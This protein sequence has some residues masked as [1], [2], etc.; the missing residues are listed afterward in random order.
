MRDA[1]TVQLEMQLKINTQTQR[2][3]KEENGKIEMTAV[4]AASA[5]TTAT[6]TRIR[7]VRKY[8]CICIC[9]VCVVFL[10]HFSSKPITVRPKRD[11]ERL[12]ERQSTQARK[13]R[14]LFLS[15]TFAQLLP[16]RSPVVLP[17]SFPALS[18][19]LLLP[20]RWLSRLF[21]IVSS[22]KDSIT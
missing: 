2:R 14:E 8:V 4:T 11:R 6:T 17:Q 10:W 16:L 15:A 18:L 13:S 1:R 5:S 21:N 9:C 7:N 22:L 19:S 20:L 3:A 12:G